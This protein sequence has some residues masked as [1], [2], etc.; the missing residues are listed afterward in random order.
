MKRGGTAKQNTKVYAGAIWR[1]TNTKGVLTYLE[2]LDLT[3]PGQPVI[4]ILLFMGMSLIATLSK[5][6]IKMTIV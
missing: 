3:G 5:I 4:L 6:W 2:T 1:K